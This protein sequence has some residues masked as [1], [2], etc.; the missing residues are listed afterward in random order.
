[1]T[2]RARLI[3]AR[4]QA[5]RSAIDRLSPDVLD[6][7][8]ART[9]Q[10]ALD[11]VGRDIRRRGGVAEDDERDVQRVADRLRRATAGLPI[12]ASELGPWLLGER[13]ASRSSSEER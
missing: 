3:A 8:L 11:G 1:M 7:P 2:D 13:A 12:R 5:L 4:I 6:V 10:A 9:L